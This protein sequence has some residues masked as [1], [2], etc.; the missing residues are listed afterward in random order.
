LK[1]HEYPAKAFLAQYGIPVS[2]GKVASPPAEAREIVTEIGPKVV[3]K[4]QVYA[5]GRGKAG[6]KDSR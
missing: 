6:G 3:I 5:G 1:I 2:R 4:A